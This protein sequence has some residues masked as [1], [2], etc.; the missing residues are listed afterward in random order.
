MQSVSI[1]GTAAT[2]AG[3]APLDKMIS[4]GECRPL[5]A[6]PHLIRR[7]L[8][9]SDYDKGY[10][11]LLSQLTT[12]TKI[13]RATF[14]TI[15]WSTS[16]NDAPHCPYNTYVIEDTQK[17]RIIATAS[18]FIEQKM[19]HGGGRVGHVEDVVVDSTYRGL[20]LGLRTMEMLISCARE[21]G[22]YKII[23]DCSEKNVAFYEKLGFK[24]KEVEM[25][26]YFEPR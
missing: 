19:I 3:A 25:A 18:V 4:G 26:L 15:F 13:P 14:E 11:E 24:Q 23:L 17:Q 16:G 1:S 12:T 5:S 9:V 8:Q 22:C 21:K 6:A 7:R 10:L 20:A 2:V